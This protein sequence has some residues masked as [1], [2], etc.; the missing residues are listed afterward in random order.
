MG[1]LLRCEPIPFLPL[2][3]I[4]IP[5]LG[6]GRGRIAVFCCNFLPRKWLLIHSS[7]LREEPE[8]GYLLRCEPIPFLPLHGIHIPSLGDGKGRVAFS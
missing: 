6:D 7:F 5:S 3:G 1:Y 2:Y 4:H 8:M